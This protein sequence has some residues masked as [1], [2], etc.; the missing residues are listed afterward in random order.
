MVGG[1]V[2][3]PGSLKANKTGSWRTFRPTI[4]GAKCIGCGMCKKFCPDVCIEITNKKAGI[5]YDYCK[6]CLLCVS[7]CPV[8]AI[9][10]KEEEK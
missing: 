7:V 3:E 6:G 9:S 10:S 1:I 2:Y 4:D 8:K 5:D